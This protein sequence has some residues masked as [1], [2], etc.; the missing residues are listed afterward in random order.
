MRHEIALLRAPKTASNG[1]NHEENLALSL[2]AAALAAL[3]SGCAYWTTLTNTATDAG[4]ASRYA[5][6]V[7]TD[8]YC[9]VGGHRLNCR[10]DYDWRF[11]P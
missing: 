2:S 6:A 4:N 1:V 5:Y 3:L 7:P 8:N 11:C 9:Y 10:F